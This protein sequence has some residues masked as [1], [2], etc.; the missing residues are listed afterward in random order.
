MPGDQRREKVRE[1]YSAPP[2]PAY[3]GS[4]SLSALRRRAERSAFARLLDQAIPPGARVLE[5]GCGTGQMS[6]FLAGAE[7]VVVGADLTRA[8]L[9]LAEA[10]RRRY[11]I[12]EVRFVET[13]LRKPGLRARAF[14]VGIS[15]GGLHHTPDRRRIWPLSWVG[16]S[17]SAPRAALSSPAA[18]PGS[19][20]RLSDVKE[21]R[22]R[23]SSDQGREGEVQSTIA[24]PDRLRRRVEPPGCSLSGG[25]E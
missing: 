18:W 1:F 14:D 3:P 11:A 2:F 4:D 13:D 21:A 6:L 7:R 5:M 9:E 12:D 10:A 24:G 8:S 20:R 16:R 23:R 17:L 25:T 15:S 19:P 22:S